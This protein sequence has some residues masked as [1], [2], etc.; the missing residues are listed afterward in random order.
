MKFNTIIIG[1]GLAGMTSAIR[2]AE[3]GEKVAVV[4]A[5]RSAL[6]FNTGSF[7]LMGFDADHRPTADWSQALSSLPA[8]H[9]YSKIGSD[10]ISALAQDAL[11]LL[12]RSGL[13][14]YCSE[15]QNNHGRISPLG[16]FRPAWLSLEGLLTEN[17]LADLRQRRVALIGLAGFLD[18]YPR[19]I[20]ASLRKASCETD[21]FTVDTPDLRTLRSSETEMRAAN[22]ARILHG[23]PLKRFAEEIK[24]LDI[25]SES[26]IVLP[27]VIDPSELE[28]FRSLVRRQVL[29]APT[30]GVS[31]PGVYIHDALIRRFKSLGGRIL[32]GHRVNGAQFGDNRLIGVTTDKLDDDCL[33]ADSFVFAGGS[34]F[35]HGLL[36]HPDAIVE[37]VLGLDT[38]APQD[39]NG[40]FE[41][42]LFGAQPVMK[43]GVA[44]NESF[45]A[46]RN[47]S[48]IKNLYVVGSALSGADSVREES[49]AGVAM[50]SAIAVADTIIKNK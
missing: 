38:D 49:G 50:I 46:K 17:S 18:F 30:L 2:L 3:S 42:D 10:K 34:F 21:I 32:N 9:P 27:A 37:P 12:K 40:W 22:I 19:F 6:L 24:K 43:S 48:V 23:Y 36:A 33:Y 1:G 15:A 44:T 31:L 29:F 7:G 25:P 13:N 45:N 4:S 26:I 41:A 5:G 39:R 47:G 14:F 16:I 28:V 11:S 8:A 20:A 35:S